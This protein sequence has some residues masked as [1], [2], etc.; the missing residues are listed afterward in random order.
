MTRAERSAFETALLSHVGLIR[1][2]GRARLDDRSALDDFTQEVLTSAYAY[3]SRH[4]DPDTLR[5]WL[6]TVARNMATDWNRKQ[7]PTPVAS[8]PEVAAADAP[9]RAAEDSERW[10][11]LL[12]ALDALD[13]TDRDIVY[14]RY[15]QD[16]SYDV[17]GRRHGLSTEAIGVRL[18]RSLRRLRSR[19]E[20]ALAAIGATWA[21]RSRGA[22]VGAIGMKIGHVSTSTA[23]LGIAFLVAFGVGITVIVWD[24]RDAASDALAAGASTGLEPTSARRGAGVGGR[25]DSDPALA[26]RPPATRPLPPGGERVSDDAASTEAG[27]PA[28]PRAAQLPEATQREQAEAAVAGLVS[29]LQDYDPTVD[30]DALVQLSGGEA[31]RY[32]EAMAEYY[33]TDDGLG[34]RDADLAQM[35]QVTLLGQSFGDGEM[36]ASLGSRAAPD[37]LPIEMILRPSDGAWRV[38]QVRQATR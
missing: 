3:R 4:G 33:R 13:P 14:R 21:I 38:V 16:E 2:I 27:S 19:L 29:A 37:E 23:A 18:H 26:T 22:A 9:D 8:L 32:F 7:R 17:I 20:A 28:G 31:R 34:G 15:F 12:D 10:G 24:R 25:P 11:A 1:H 30:A 5:R 35:R 36:V 6:A